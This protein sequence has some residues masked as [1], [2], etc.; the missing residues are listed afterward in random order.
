MLFAAVTRTP[1][2]IFGLSLAYCGAAII[3]PVAFG[4]LHRYADDNARA[5]IESAVSLAERL[6]SVVVGLLFGY[7]STRLDVNMGFAVLGW[8][9]IIATICFAFAYR[10]DKAFTTD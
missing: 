10:F 8:L 4:H 2:G 9:V 6:I 3:Y 1:I 7:I 5:T